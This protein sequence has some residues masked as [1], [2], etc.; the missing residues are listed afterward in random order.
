MPQRVFVSSRVGRSRETWRRTIETEMT[1][2]GKIWNKLRWLAKERSE[3][4]KLL[5]AY[6]SQVAEREGWLQSEQIHNLT[7]D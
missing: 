7:K 4:R 2:E 1:E 3:W 5:C 6:A